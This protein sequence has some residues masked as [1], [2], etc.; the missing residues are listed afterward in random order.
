MLF[1]TSGWLSGLWLRDEARRLRG[2]HMSMTFID[3]DEHDLEDSRSSEDHGVGARTFES[4]FAVL[5][6]E[7]PVQILAGAFVSFRAGPK[8][9][10]V[11][12]GLCDLLVQLGL[13]FLLS[14]KHCILSVGSHY[15]RCYYREESL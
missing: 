9:V 14:T 5:D 2:P 1:A 13:I 6:L 7:Q 11:G 12:I 3:S 8:R 4:A 10:H 15:R